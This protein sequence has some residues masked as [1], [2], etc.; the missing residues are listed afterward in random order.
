MAFYDIALSTNIV[1]AVTKT[2]SDAFH[3]LNQNEILRVFVFQ[4]PRFPQM[5]GVT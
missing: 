3:V 1:L 4:A 5:T 2:V